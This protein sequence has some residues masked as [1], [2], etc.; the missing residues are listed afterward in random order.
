MNVMNSSKPAILFTVTVSLLM[1]TTAVEAGAGSN[2]AV[3]TSIEGPLV[4]EAT[5]YN[6]VPEQTE[7][8]PSIAAWGDRLKPGD[9]AV[10]VSDD[11]L[12]LGLVRGTRVRIEGLPGEY[13]VL[14]RMHSRWQRRIDI[15]MGKDIDAALDWGR[16]DVR[17]YWQTP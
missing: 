1:S 11:L 5:A 15:Y 14:D 2:G 10:A 12:D 7:G 13:L 4:V 17:I 3:H 16:K 8:D 9:S 6:C